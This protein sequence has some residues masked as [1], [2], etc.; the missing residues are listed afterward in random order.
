MLYNMYTYDQIRSSGNSCIC[1]PVF[2]SIY[3][4]DQRK[5][6]VLDYAG[7]GSEQHE[8]YH[9]TKRTCIGGTFLCPTVVPTSVHC[10]KLMYGMPCASTSSGMK[11]PLPP[12]SEVA[13]A[14]PPPPPAFPFPFLVALSLGSPRVT[15]HITDPRMGEG[16]CSRVYPN[17]LPNSNGETRLVPVPSIIFG[18]LGG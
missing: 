12:P 2:S 6:L 9:N 1:F 3:C 11:A 4:L 13:P 18:Y 8:P 17:V 10:A 15:C 16:G 14:L 7:K 5:L